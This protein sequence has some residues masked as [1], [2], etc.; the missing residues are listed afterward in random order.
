[1]VNFAPTQGHESTG[2]KGQ[3]AVYVVHEMLKRGLI[4]IKQNIET[5]TE[6]DMQISGTDIIVHSNIRIQ[7]KCD[8]KAGT[9]ELGGTGN[10]F[11]Q[12]AECNPFGSV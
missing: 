6:Q 3:K 4:P 2:T 7:V 12:T 10:L 9:K 8:W 5:I 1:M 11:I